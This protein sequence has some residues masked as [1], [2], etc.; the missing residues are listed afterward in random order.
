MDEKHQ[1]YN[2][3]LHY[4]SPT[5]E[6][7]LEKKLIDIKSFNN[8]IIKGKELISYLRDRNHKSQKKNKKL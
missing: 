8:S 1:S 3:L 4:W 6:Q 5:M 2:P 7:R